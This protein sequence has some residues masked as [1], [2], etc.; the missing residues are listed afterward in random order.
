MTAKPAE[1]AGEVGTDF[2]P[3]VL[4]EFETTLIIEPEACLRI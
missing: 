2:G 1:R 4:P 3:G